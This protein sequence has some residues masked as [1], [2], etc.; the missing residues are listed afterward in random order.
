MS[1]LWNED[2]WRDVTRRLTR[3]AMSE[4]AHDDHEVSLLESRARDLSV[5][6]EEAGDIHQRVVTFTVN[7]ETY[8]IAL[9]HAREIVPVADTTAVPG[10]PPRLLGLFNL[11]GAILPLFD[12][13]SLFGSGARLVE[14][15]GLVIVVG[16]EAPEL[17]IATES[18][19]AIAALRDEDILPPAPTMRGEGSLVHG[20]TRDGVI[21][22]DGEALLR[23]PRLHL[24]IAS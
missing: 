16:R 21:L 20:I 22:L 18:V 19:G 23:D 8:G 6:S 11:R 3:L 24:S 10:T 2:F 17:A 1:D 9:E 4:T 7:G 12:L 5:P 14:R 15:G 13:A